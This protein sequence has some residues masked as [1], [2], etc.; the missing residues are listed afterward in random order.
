MRA[1]GL[2]TGLNQFSRRA[3]LRSVKDKPLNWRSF[4]G[5]WVVF[6]FC[7]HGQSFC[8]V[9]L[10]QI[11]TV[12]RLYISNNYLL[13]L[14]FQI[15]MRYSY[16][17][18]LTILIVKIIFK[19]QR[20]THSPTKQQA[21]LN[22]ARYI[23]KGITWKILKVKLPQLQAQARVFGAATGCSIGE[24]RLSFI[25]QWCEWTRSVANSRFTQRQ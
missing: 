11:R 21:G 13:N 7:S 17:S 3:C 4:C 18:M 14:W 6:C 16:Q 20:I 22:C 15:H 19:P 24:A 23:L 9:Q 12:S 5:F 10:S 2:N 8:P 25:A 1:I